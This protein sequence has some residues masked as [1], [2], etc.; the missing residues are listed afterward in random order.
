MILEEPFGP[1]KKP[2]IQFNVFLANYVVSSVPGNIKI[3]KSKEK[4][5]L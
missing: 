2:F 5:K 4:E 3:Q 1:K